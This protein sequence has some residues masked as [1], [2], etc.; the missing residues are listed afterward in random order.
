MCGIP[1]LLARTQNDLETMT[2]YLM[3]GQRAMREWRDTDHDSS[4]IVPTVSAVLADQNWKMQIAS[5]PA[6][7]LR[8]DNPLLLDAPIFAGFNFS[9]IEYTVN[10]HL[11]VGN[12]GHRPYCGMMKSRTASVVG[13]I[14]PIGS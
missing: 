7:F 5:D 11:D 9:N 12:P 2:M 14:T 13:M 6:S 8:D 1:V 4:S 3:Y 10:G